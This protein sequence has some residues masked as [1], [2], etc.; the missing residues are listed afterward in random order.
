MG[1]QRK[2]VRYLAVPAILSML[3]WLVLL[4]PVSAQEEPVAEPG[5]AAEAQP[6]AAE[7]EQPEAEAE[8]TEP[9]KVHEV[10]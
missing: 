5:P 2:V 1:T 10:Q 7:E 8:P 4:G 6:P 3:A 9:K